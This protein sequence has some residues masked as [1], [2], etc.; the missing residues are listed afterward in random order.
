MAWAREVLMRVI[1]REIPLPGT[2]PQ[3]DSLLFRLA[4]VEQE[5]E[6]EEQVTI[7]IQMSPEA[8][9]CQG[10]IESSRMLRG[11]CSVAVSEL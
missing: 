1:G 3:L 10:M 2:I 11:V 9:L 7:V 5:E 6:E 8:Q 4:V